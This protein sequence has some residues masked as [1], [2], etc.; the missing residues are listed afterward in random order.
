V[1]PILGVA[2][3]VLSFFFLCEQAVACVVGQT[4]VWLREKSTAPR[5]PWMNQFKLWW[6]GRDTH[7]RAFTPYSLAR[8]CFVH[9]R[10]AIP[11]SGLHFNELV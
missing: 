11:S 2:P 4:A 5:P 6:H 1:Q 7:I 3:S 9:L 8:G 10:F